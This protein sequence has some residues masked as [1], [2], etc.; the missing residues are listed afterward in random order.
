MHPRRLRLGTHRSRIMEAE[1]LRH[2]YQEVRTLNQPSLVTMCNGFTPAFFRVRKDPK[3]I[4][5]FH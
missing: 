1:A 5:V 4:D 3:L 2:A